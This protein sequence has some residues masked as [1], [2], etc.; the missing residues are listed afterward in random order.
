MLSV[1]QRVRD[2]VA[3]VLARKRGQA[4]ESIPLDTPLLGEGLGLD[5]ADT[6]G[7][8]VTIEDAFSIQFDDQDLT[9]D[10]FRDIGTL[11]AAVAGKLG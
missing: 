2:M 5:S 8:V 3:Q 11:A 6:L 7:L 4:P 10:V 1:A 9:A